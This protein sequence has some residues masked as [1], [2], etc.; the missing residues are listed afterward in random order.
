M[1]LFNNNDDFAETGTIFRDVI[2]LA[3]L[4]MVAIVILLL[5]HIHPPKQSEKKD[6]TAPGSLIVE[7]LWP[8]EYNADVDTWVIAP[9]PGGNPIG[10]SNK[11]GPIFNL[12][13]DDLGNNNDI[14]ELNYENVFSRGIPDG[15][16]VINLHL[17]GTKDNKFPVP[18][19]VVISIKSNGLTKQVL[20]SDVF[21]TGRKEEITV[22]NFQIHD[23]K[24]VRDTVN[25]DYFPIKTR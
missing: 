21:L 12:L 3:L 15:W 7:V 24:L 13:R 11:A 19:K 8:I 20:V 4:G 23:K 6:I 18:V 17:Y 10:F 16:Y 14:T 9:A 2:V 1:D 22:F 5:P 25:N